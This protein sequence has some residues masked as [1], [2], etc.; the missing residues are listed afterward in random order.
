[1]LVTGHFEKLIAV[2]MTVLANLLLGTLKFLRYER[3]FDIVLRD[4]QKKGGFEH[5]Y[6]SKDAPTNVHTEDLS[7][8]PFRIIPISLELMGTRRTKCETV[9]FMSISLAQI[10]GKPSSLLIQPGCSCQAGRDLSSRMGPCECSVH[11]LQNEKCWSSLG[12]HPSARVAFHETF[13][14]QSRGWRR[15]NKGLLSFLFYFFPPVHSLLFQ[16]FSILVMSVENDGLSV[17]FDRTHESWRWFHVL[18]SRKACL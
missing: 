11:S 4:F 8:I 3:G 12:L 16:R 7:P 5:I 6:N 9:A 15:R 17:L 2:L 13:E 10:T 14:Y 1:M 18:H